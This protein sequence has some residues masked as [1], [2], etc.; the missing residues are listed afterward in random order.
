M[1][2]EVNKND[3]L[4]REKQLKFYFRLDNSVTKVE[5][6]DIRTDNPQ[7]LPLICN[8]RILERIKQYRECKQK[9]KMMNR[10]YFK[11]KLKNPVKLE[12]GGSWCIKILLNK[13]EK[14]IAESIPKEWFNLTRLKRN[15][16]KEE[17]LEYN[18]KKKLYSFEFRLIPRE[19]S[20]KT[21]FYL[22]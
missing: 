9:V 16:C 18:D 1:S 17:I 20:K 6:V 12:K 3:G 13:V 11:I 15:F 10:F 4:Y 2:K 5:L 21:R 19:L 7:I 22:Y 8:H 14:R